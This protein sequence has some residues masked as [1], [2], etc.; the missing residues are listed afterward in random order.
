VDARP[1]RARAR[2]LLPAG[3]HADFARFG[4]SSST[5][6]RVDGTPILA[7]GWLD[8]ATRKQ[9]DIGAPG[10]GYGYH[11]WTVDNGTFSALGIHGQ[12]VL[13]DPGRRFDHRDQQRLAGGRLHPRIAGRAPG[14]DAAI[15]AAIDARAQ[16]PAGK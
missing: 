12:Q 14:P 1:Q 11:W 4:R 9:A 5:A 3:Q 13:V 8:A 2:R 10:R 6:W 16:G 15:R 7:D